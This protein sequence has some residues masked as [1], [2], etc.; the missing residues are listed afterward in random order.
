MNTMFLLMAEFETS[1]I[2]LSVIAERYLGMRPSTADKK[3]G[4]GELPI[5]TFRIGNS[6]KSPRVVHVKDLADFIDSQR[7]A[8]KE[9]LKNSQ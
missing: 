7:K 8:A 9:E 1:T 3:A 6:Q 4:C 5:P 2:P